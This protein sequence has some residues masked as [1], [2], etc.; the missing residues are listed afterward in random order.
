MAEA[1]KNTVSMGHRILG[2]IGLAAFCVGVVL[3]IVYGIVSRDNAG[4]TLT[5]VIVG[6]IVGF[7]NITRREVVLLLVATVAL[8]VVGKT[9]FTPL[10]DLVS[11]LGNSLNGIVSY[12]AIFM[13]P[14]A[15][16][17]AFRAMWAVARPG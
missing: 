4:V 6:I 5:L 11:G 7:L 15:V 1:K 12:L 3:A 13:A 2:Y 9:G 16:I 17:S 14:A 8:I 10:N